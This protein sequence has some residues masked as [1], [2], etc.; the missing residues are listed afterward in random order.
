MAES[1]NVLLVVFG[2]LF[3][4]SLGSF[5]NVVIDRVPQ[6]KSLLAPPSHCD[7]CG[8]RLSAF[9]LIPVFSYL[10]LRG[11]CRSC[12]ARVPHRVLWVELIAGAGAAGA[13]AF[14]GLSS[15][16]VMIYFSGV[17]LLTLSVIDIELGIV[18]DQIVLP[19]TAI[20]LVAAVIFPDVG[21]KSALLGGGISLGVL[22]LPALLRRGSMGGGDITLAP[23]LGIVSGY[24]AILVGLLS[25][26][27][28]GG[29]AGAVILLTRKGN[30]KTPLPF[31]PF[32]SVGVLIGL[33]WGRTIVR[34]YVG[35]F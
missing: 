14:Y 28:L 4:I 11:R 32:L 16:G 24:P 22:L 15:P 26:F 10:A 5:L 27:L 19:A 29:A 17:V 2:F 9:E 1:L 35:Q 20:A 12:S 18:P 7:S 3:G 23:F 33:V 13:A 8:A 25:A 30:G 6:G 21:W 34:W 31:V